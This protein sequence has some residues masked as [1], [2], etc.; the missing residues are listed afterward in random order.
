MVVEVFVK[1]YI[2]NISTFSTLIMKC[3]YFDYEVL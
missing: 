2:V 1:C 3:Y